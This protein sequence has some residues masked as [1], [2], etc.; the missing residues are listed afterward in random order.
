MEKFID[1]VRKVCDLP[2]VLGYPLFTKLGGAEGSPVKQQA[3]E[4]WWLQHNLLSASP[5]KRMFEILRSDGKDHL[6]Y[7]DFKPLMTAILQNHPGL[8][9]LGET[10][11]FQTRYAE[12][13][14]YRIFY[15]LNR[16]G[17]GRL[18]LRELNKGDLL[19]ALQTLD[20][21]EDINK[22]LK[23]FSYEHFYVIY[24]KFWE[25]DTDHDFLIDKD[26]LL[27]YGGCSLTYRIVDRIFEQA[28]RRFSCNVQG[29]MG[30]EDFVW[31]ILS[32]ED[33]TTDTALEYWFR[34]IDLDCDGVILSAEML[35]FYEEQAKRLESIAQEPVAFEDVACQLHDMLAPQEEGKYTLRDLKRVRPL[36]G[37][38]FSILCNLHKFLAFENRDPFAARQQEQEEAGLTEWERWARLEYIRL[39]TEE[40]HDELGMETGDD[41]WGGA[42]DQG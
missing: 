11:E 5:V 39:A 9:F 31:F 30:Y 17:S 10:P 20:R 32:E 42:M 22:V 38:L 23:Y 36:S 15:H 28:P 14:T 7:D 13:V 29:K 4:K 3:F 8:E 16:S 18:T 41:V 21:E 37:L 35:Y 25:L 12:T 27:K 24:C 6:T 26:D 2:T 34:C 19:E 1:A 40:E 33:K